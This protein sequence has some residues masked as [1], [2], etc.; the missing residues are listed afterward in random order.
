LKAADTKAFVVSV[1]MI[2][3]QLLALSILVL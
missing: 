2:W 1:D 3:S